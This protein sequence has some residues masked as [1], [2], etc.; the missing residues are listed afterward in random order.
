MIT[1]GKNFLWI[2]VYRNN[3][4]DCTGGG[5]TSRVSD[6]TVFFDC[7]REAAIEYCMENDINPEEQLFLVK[8]QLWK[9]DHFYAEPLVK[10]ANAEKCNQVFGGN[11]IMTSDGRFPRQNGLTTAYPIP[12]HDRYENY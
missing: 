5:L 1:I 8:R 9:E 2:S 4:G 6:L 7:T 10:P 3:L 11:Y 12:V